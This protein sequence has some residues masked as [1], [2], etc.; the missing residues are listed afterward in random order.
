M[1]GTSSNSG[2][3]RGIRRAF[4]LVIGLT[5]VSLFVIGVA[6]PPAWA[7]QTCTFSSGTQQLILRRRPLVVATHVSVRPQASLR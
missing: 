1:G 6:S 4:A 3:R 5:T 7:A 2:T